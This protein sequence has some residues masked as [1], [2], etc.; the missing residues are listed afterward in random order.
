MCVLKIPFP[1][2]DD[3]DSFLCC[4]LKACWFYILDLGLFSLLCYLLCL[5]RDERQ[6]S[7]FHI[8]VH[9]VPE[10]TAMYAPHKDA[11]L[12]SIREHRLRRSVSRHYVLCH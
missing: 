8:G 3:E 2:K 4:P 10:K 6:D 11:P 7:F 12:P 5:V 9:V 1:Y